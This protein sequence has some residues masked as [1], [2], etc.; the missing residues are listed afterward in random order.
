MTG[1]VTSRPWRGAVV[2]QRPNDPWVSGAPVVPRPGSS[3]AVATSP[4]GMPT[5][6]QGTLGHV[7]ALNGRRTAELAIEQVAPLFELDPSALRVESSETDELGATHLT[8]RQ[9]IDG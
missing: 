2:S 8:L 1:L 3:R 6:V 5:F 4:A 9:V 7:D